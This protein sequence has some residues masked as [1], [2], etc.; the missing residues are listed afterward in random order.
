MRTETPKL[1]WIDVFEFPSRCR[2]F[3]QC[4]QRFKRIKYEN[5]SIRLKHFILIIKPTL[6]VKSSILVQVFFKNQPPENTLMNKTGASKISDS[7]KTQKA[8]S[9]MKK[10]RMALRK[11]VKNFRR[12]ELHP[13][14]EK[15]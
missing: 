6:L 1:S 4:E 5:I 3:L 11:V 8:R 15:V 9:L 10:L 2:T 13:P 12:G 7:L 14:N